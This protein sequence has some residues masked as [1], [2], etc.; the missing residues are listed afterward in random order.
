LKLYIR[1]FLL[2]TLLSST[3]FSGNIFKGCGDT[4]DQAREELAKSIYVSIESNFERN[5]SLDGE[6]ANR[7][8]KNVS[9]QSTLLKGL[10]GIKTFQ[11]ESRYCA[12]IEKAQ[13]HQSLDNEKTKVNSIKADSTNLDELKSG[14]ESCRT[15][16]ALA[17][18]LSVTDLLKEFSNKR[19]EFESRID[20]IEK[21]RIVATLENDV[22]KINQFRVDEDE[23]SEFPKKV[24]DK[25]E[26]MIAL[27][28]KVIKDAERI[29][30]K[31]VIKVVSAKKSYFES[32][33][34]TI[35][36]QSVLF[37][38]E[39][40][41]S[42][43]IYIDGKKSPFKINKPIFL[44]EGEHQ[45]KIVENGYC[46]IVGDF[47]LNRDEEEV[48]D[49]IYLKDHTL[50]KVKFTSN[51]DSKN[52][53]LTVDNR[54]VT[55]GES[56]T[57]DKS[58]CSGKSIKYLAEFSEN[59]IK[60]SEDGTISLSA[61]LDKSIHIEFL[62]L[63]DIKD[64]KEEFKPYIDGDRVEILYSYGH[65]SDSDNNLTKG[66]HNISINKL[67]QKRFWRYGYG[68]LAGVDDTEAPTT[69]AF[70]L[71]YLLGV[72]FTSFGKNEMPI[73]IGKWSIIPYAGVE[74][75]VGYHEYKLDDGEKV[76]T[77]PKEDHE[78]W[79]EDPR[80]YG[81]DFVRD[82]LVVKPTVGIDF[83]LSKGF[84]LKIFGEK[85]LYMDRRLYIGTGLSVE[86]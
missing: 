4:Q 48:I 18:V 67:T 80:E 15:G 11:E 32:Q 55:L 26:E 22:V 49:N 70:E 21:D 60:D 19:Q 65:V 78:D 40:G 71:Y 45:Y 62:S 84:A 75:G 37:N 72:Q 1:Y 68:L 43:N 52:I 46:D 83:V 29:N 73:H 51:Q 20:K 36:T 34:N 5:E 12:S 3:L 14:V 44:S 33:L 82:S 76:W 66:T 7:T 31:D 42:L 38:I 41:Q 85:N 81:Y 59:G 6:S 35:Y 58:R 64:I 63:S 39:G 17:S 30:S 28:S 53:T 10:V 23:K 54:R 47:S 27:A 16:E 86:F 61:G 50:P 2:I 77:Y 13:L 69:K 57:F 74:F 79:N 8:L 25:L 9:K 56:L 24:R